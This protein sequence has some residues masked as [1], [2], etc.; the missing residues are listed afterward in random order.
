MK[1]SWIS[2]MLAVLLI[3]GVVVVVVGPGVKAEEVVK[4]GAIFPLTGKA[5]STGVKLKYAV[6]TAEEL[7]NGVYPEINVPLAKKAGLPGLGGAKVE[8]V[9]ADHQANPGVAKSEAERLI[10]NE[11]VVGLI[12]CYH[13]SSTKPASQVA[14]M[15]GIPFVAGSSS[16]AALTERGL[17]YF[18]R[19]APNDDMETEFFFEY[20][21]FLNESYDA[22]IKTVGVVYIDN[23][24]G[25]HA[26]EMVDKW[27]EEKYGAQGYKKVVD[28]KYPGD[29]SNVDIEV[30][31]IKAANP[32]VI[33]HASYIGDM[34]QFVKKYKEFDFVPKASLSYCGGFQDPQFLINLENDANYF[35]G[36]NQAVPALIKNVEI[37]SKIN[38]I[39]K[40]K[41]GVDFDGPSLE[42]FASA[43][44][45]AD[46][47]NK[48]GSTDPDKIMAIL[49][50]TEFSAPYFMT[51]KIKFNEKGQNIYS[52]S[53][54]TQ[55]IDS[56]YEVVWPVDIQTKVPVPDFV[57]WSER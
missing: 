11:D 13:S 21:N 39:Y 45:I 2:L 34:T 30:Q 37:L 17:N 26:A 27:L 38:E 48:A 28:V 44:V 8:F 1:R 49:K 6:E 55:V 20:L 19:I 40:E 9:F 41:S 42:D 50:D 14:E 35:A 32:D 18:V 5:A 57:E 25:V 10:Q 16:S 31:K 24:Y 12:G 53:V 4:I 22:G 56:K 52:A 43:M 7:I 47:I 36:T 23:E 54:M 3:L 15:Y 33:F 51:G 29:L 46:A